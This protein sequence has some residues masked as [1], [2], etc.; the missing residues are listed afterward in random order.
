MVYCNQLDCR[1]CKKDLSQGAV[2]VC[3]L[4][5]IRMSRTVAGRGFILNCH[6]FKYR[7]KGLLV[8]TISPHEDAEG[9]YP[10]QHQLAANLKAYHSD[11]ESVEAVD[12]LDSLKD[13]KS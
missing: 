2:L 11:A 13:C 1:H 6:N 8:E 4:D 7:P 9:L 10:G 5:D 3:G 12:G